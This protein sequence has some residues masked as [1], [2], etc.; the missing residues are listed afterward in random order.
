MSPS[1]WRASTAPSALTSY[2][3]RS[4]RSHNSI[5]AV[6][7]TSF[8]LPLRCNPDVMPVP[9]EKAVQSAVQLYVYGGQGKGSRILRLGFAT[10]AGECGE[11]RG[12]GVGAV[13][14]ARWSLFFVI[15]YK[16]D[17]VI[18]WVF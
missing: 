11:G 14:C 6:F 3:L 4:S 18:F 8:D 7:L 1:T 12:S 15:V 9:D 2:G 16:G 10:P 5:P 17:R 13:A